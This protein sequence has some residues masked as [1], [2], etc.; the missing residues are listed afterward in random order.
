MKTPPTNQTNEW[1]V[2]VEEILLKFDLGGAGIPRSKGGFSLEE[3]TQK[4]TQLLNRAIID[5]QIDE[6]G[7]VEDYMPD[8][9]ASVGYIYT[10]Q[11]IRERTH[12]LEELRTQ[13]ISED[14][15]GLCGSTGE[16]KLTPP[17]LHHQDIFD[18]NK[19]THNKESGGRE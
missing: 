3:A 7:R 9:F 13:D 1:A 15:C 18:H 6:L 16:C 2:E 10:L 11:K 14:C 17:C 4:I 12:Y 8:R 5:A 19:R